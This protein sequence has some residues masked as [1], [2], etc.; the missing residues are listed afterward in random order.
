MKPAER[1]VKNTGILYIRM[2][3]SV[4][5][6]LYSTRLILNALGTDDFG[7]FNLVGG[8]ISMLMFLNASMTQATQRFMSYSQGAGDKDEQVRIF[9][10][11]MALHILI[12]LIMFVVL[13]IAGYFLFNGILNVSAARITAAK[14]IY[15]FLI[16]STLFTIIS[17]PYDAV[18]NAHENMLVFALVSLLE[19]FL[20][21]I[22]AF[23]ITYTYY[24]KLI[25]YG[26]L[27]ASVAIV[28]LLI[29][30]IYCHA[31]YS[32]CKI[33]MF[34]YFDLNLF[35]KMS[36]FA[37]WTFLGTMVGMLSNFGQGIVLNHFFG[38]AINA[39]QGIANQIAGQ[40]GAFSTTMLKALNP[41]LVKSEGSGKRNNMLQ[42]SMTGA[43]LSYFLLFV[44]SIPIWIE[45]KYVLNIWLKDVPEYAVVF[46]RLLLIKN[47]I[48]QMFV[49]LPI[50][51]SAVGN[52]KQFQIKISML[53]ILPLILSYF[54]FKQGHP[55]YTIY[56][57][58]IIQ[59]FI[60]S[61]AIVLYYAKKLC[62]LSVKDYLI[63]VVLRC[64]IVS[65]VVVLS[66][67]VFNRT[68][69]IGIFRFGF[70]VIIGFISFV[71]CLFIVGFTK[72][73][74]E[75]IRILLGSF[76]NKLIQFKA[77]YVR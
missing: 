70:E 63:D 8:A 67:L 12:A 41:S 66:I 33:G 58:F 6:S 1:V 55:P 9:N 17:V 43:K 56:W 14:Y 74:K 13:E 39:A 16:C 20:R 32:E 72:K 50:S 73:E 2:I 52:I 30:R 77:A 23:Y 57:L 7:I 65:F 37:G 19:T 15:Q 11:S 27:M 59:V 54:L 25:V 24:D 22:I 68:M 29:R 4:F 48:E 49:T 26:L 42:S 46:C 21:L 28:S 75:F 76:F 10:V 51:I 38:T 53:A 64:T 47:L 44:I 60:R 34:R 36:S 35:K 18:I 61:F 3:L 62:G 31:K 40:L 69:A 45:M 71:L 5:I